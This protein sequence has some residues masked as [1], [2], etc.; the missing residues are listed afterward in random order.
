[1]GRLCI[2]YGEGIV[3]YRVSV[4]NLREREYLKY[5]GIDARLI[6]KWIFKKYH[7]LWT[8]LI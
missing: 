7:G 8:G 3:T 1:M 6:L 4:G 2:I 5:L